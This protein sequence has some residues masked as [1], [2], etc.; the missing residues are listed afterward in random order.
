M[1]GLSGT[2]LRDQQSGVVFWPQGEDHRDGELAELPAVHLLHQCHAAICGEDLLPQGIL[3]RSRADDLFIE[4][5]HKGGG[6]LIDVRTPCPGEH[7]PDGIEDVEDLAGGQRLL[8]GP[9]PAV[10]S[11]SANV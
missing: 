5:A 2:D 8:L 6:E 10:A 4:R 1:S 9:G 7:G 3:F 11:Y